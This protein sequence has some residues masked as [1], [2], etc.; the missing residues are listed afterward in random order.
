PF[1]KSQGPPCHRCRTQTLNISL[2]MGKKI[3]KM[4]MTS[5]MIGTYK[6]L[7]VCYHHM[8]NS[9]FLWRPL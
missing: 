1:F 7:V 6:I 3:Q 5:K 2:V 9:A 4:R 8:P